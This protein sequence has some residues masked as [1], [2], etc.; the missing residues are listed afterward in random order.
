MGEQIVEVLP[1][2]EATEEPEDENDGDHMATASPWQTGICQRPTE[3][4]K[5]SQQGITSPH[6]Q[7]RRS[8]RVQRPNPKYANAA[9]AE[10]ESPKELE[11]YDEAP[12]S[13]VWVKAM[14]EEIR[15]GAKSNMGSHAKTT[16]CETHIVQM[17]IQDQDS[18]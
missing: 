14:K 3:E 4:V 12:K 13:F 5:P 10:E 1:R 7:L 9:V 15:V 11:T 17:D 18:P 6:K 8:T 2:P 16:R